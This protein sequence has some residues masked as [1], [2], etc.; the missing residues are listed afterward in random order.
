M[1]RCGPC[2]PR[3]GAGSSRGPPSTGRPSSSAF[4]SP[5]RRCSW[6]RSASP[7]GR[8]RA[9]LARGG[10]ERAAAVL[11]HGLGDSLESYVD[12]GATHAPGYRETVLGFL[13]A[14]GL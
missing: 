8:L 1:D 11:V 13:E 9:W 7:P 5:P 3:G 4:P 14:N 6:G 10:E 12:S 2:L